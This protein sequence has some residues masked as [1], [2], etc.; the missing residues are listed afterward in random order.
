M[1]NFNKKH[2]K[3]VGFLNSKMQMKEINSKMELIRVERN[4]I[5]KNALE[6]KVLPP[7]RALFMLSLQVLIDA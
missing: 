5:A 6:L 7:Y 4:A 1:L 3:T 2:I